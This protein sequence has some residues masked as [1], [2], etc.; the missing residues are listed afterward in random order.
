MVLDMILKM[1]RKWRKMSNETWHWNTG[2]ILLIL[3]NKYNYTNITIHL[4]FCM[5]YYIVS[6]KN[7]YSQFLCTHV[8]VVCDIHMW[9]TI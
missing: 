3:N 1:I 2:H 6:L 4:N 5:S 9:Y 7:Q 8:S